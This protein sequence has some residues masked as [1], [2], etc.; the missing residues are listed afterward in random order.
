M[1]CSESSLYRVGREIRKAHP[2]SKKKHRIYRGGKEGVKKGKNVLKNRGGTDLA[3]FEK[4]KPNTPLHVCEEKAVYLRRGG[5]APL[6]LLTPKATEE[7][8]CGNREGAL[9]S[10]RQGILRIP[11]GNRF[12]LYGNRGGV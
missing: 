5:G 11:T 12:D 2:W 1:D 4:S 7:N 9:L 8:I 3:T 10:A 6:T